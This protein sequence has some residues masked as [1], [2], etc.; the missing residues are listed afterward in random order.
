MLVSCFQMPWFACHLP[1][2]AL[3][4]RTCD[5][6][7]KLLPA[8]LCKIRSRDQWRS[9]TTISIANINL[10]IKIS[11]CVTT[12]HINHINHPPYQPY[13]LHTISTTH[14]TNHIN[15]T[16]YQPYQPHIIH[17]INHT[18]YQPYQPHT[19]HHINHTPYQPREIST[20]TNT[21]PLNCHKHKPHQPSQTQTAVGT[22]FEKLV[23]DE[24][25][26]VLV[27]LFAPWSSDCKNALKIIKKVAKKVF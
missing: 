15:H 26:D 18:P 5:T 21:D 4:R 27:Q 23:L 25:V 17:H 19:I 22:T 10:P 9:N 13:Q 16:P 3:T 14:H 2:E 20:S 6:I 11:A 12:H 24:E 1:Y 7:I 8:S